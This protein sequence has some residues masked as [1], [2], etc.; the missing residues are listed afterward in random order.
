MD[1][2]E[3]TVPRIVRRDLRN[4]GLFGTAYLKQ[5]MVSDDVWTQSSLTEQLKAM[6]ELNDKYN[7]YKRVEERHKISYVKKEHR[8]LEDE[9][10]YGRAMLQKARNG[11]SREIYNIF[12]NHNNI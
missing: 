6:I 3:K 1:K 9:C 4:H 7:T 2:P 5:H 11:K 10:N 8:R 12:I